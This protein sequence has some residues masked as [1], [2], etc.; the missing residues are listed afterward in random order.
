MQSAASSAGEAD[1]TT[2]MNWSEEVTDRLDQKKYWARI[3]E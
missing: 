2:K 3:F 1:T